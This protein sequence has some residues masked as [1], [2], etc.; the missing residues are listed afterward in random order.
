MISLSTH[1]LDTGRGAPAAGVRVEL[2]GVTEAT[3]DDEGKLFADDERASFTAVLDASKD[4]AGAEVELAVDH[5]RL[6]F[7]EPST[8]ESLDATAGAKLVA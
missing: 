2:V 5:R 1:V 6:H 8:G 4:V 7:F 3:T